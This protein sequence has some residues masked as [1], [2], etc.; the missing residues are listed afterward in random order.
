MPSSTSR[1]A[2]PL[3]SRIILASASPRRREL[4][5]QIGIEADVI[6]ASID[7]ESI[8]H[9]DPATLAV[10]LA[11]AKAQAV[12]ERFAPPRRAPPASRAGGA[13]DDDIG[14]RGRDLAGR[15]L[16]AA[17]TLVV[18]AGEI[19]EKPVD[20]ADARRMVGLLSGRTHQV[21]TGVAVAWLPPAGAAVEHAGSVASPPEDRI[22]TP[23]ILARS[24]ETDVTFATLSEREIEE[25]L[26]SGE[27]RGVAGGYRV[28]GLAARYVTHLSGSYSNVVGL[29]LHLLYAILTGTRIGGTNRTKGADNHP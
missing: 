22:G 10:E 27:W 25:Y 19:L 29:P 4:L 2:D 16:L 28:Q 12:L 20:R 23:P 18:A 11:R 3:P 24:C 5:V 8:R 14:P 13:A 6:P 15:P 7:E 1:A 26:D 21:V 17:D 9:D